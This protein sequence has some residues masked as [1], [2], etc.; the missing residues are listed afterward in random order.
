[1]NRITMHYM[2]GLLVLFTFLS[3]QCQGYV[4]EHMKEKMRINLQNQWNVA[5]FW[6]IGADCGIYGYW[7]GLLRSNKIILH[8]KLYWDLSKI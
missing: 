1:M 3:H 6:S 8:A 4:P 7:L 2:V 5:V